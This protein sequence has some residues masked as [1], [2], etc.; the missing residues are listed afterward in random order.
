MEYKNCLNTVIQQAFAEYVLTFI[1]L[2]SDDNEEGNTRSECVQNDGDSTSRLHTFSTHGI[3]NILVSSTLL[4]I[5]TICQDEQRSD[6][7]HHQ[8]LFRNNNIQTCVW[9]KI[10]KKICKI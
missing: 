8:Y 7:E 10:D 4:Q 1:P 6:Y 2:I 9:K 3:N 5:G